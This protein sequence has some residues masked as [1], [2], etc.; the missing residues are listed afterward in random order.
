MPRWIVMVIVQ[1]ELMNAVFVVVTE[2]R[3]LYLVAQILFMLNSTLMQLQMMDHAKPW[4]SMAAHM[5]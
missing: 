5:K 4:S 3:A 1:K 2:R